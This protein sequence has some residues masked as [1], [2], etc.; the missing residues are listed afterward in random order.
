MSDKAE[1]EVTKILQEWRGGD[2]SAAERLFPLVYEE[3]RRQARRHLSLERSDHTLQPTA[4]VHEAYLKMIDQTILSVENRTHFFG[5]ASRIMRQILVDYARQHNAEKRGGSAQRFSI[6][7]IE[8]LPEQSAADLLELDEALQRLEAIDERK[9]RVVD[10]RFFGGL[11]EKE[12]AEVLG[13]TEK[14]VRRDWQF[15]KLWLYRELS[16]SV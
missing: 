14:T 8:I 2:T 13:V 4:L 12:I 15:A 9:C 5:I 1:S 3:L 7:D 10:M 6:E 11:K 16:K